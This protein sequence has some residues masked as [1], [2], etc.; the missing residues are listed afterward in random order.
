MNKKPVSYL[1]TDPRWKNK[2]YRVPGETATI[3][4]SGCGPTA[5][6]MLIETLTGKKYTPED[7][8][9]WSVAHG[10]KALKAGTY[11]A[12]FAPQFA[13]FGIK[14]WQLSWTNGYHNPKAKVHDQ[15]LEYL[16]Q[17]YY[18][19]ALMKKGT[20]TG[21]GHFVVVWWADNK[22][23]INDPASTKD[24]RLNGDSA[25]F[26]NEAA[27]YWVIDARAY[28]NGGA[29]T[30]PEYRTYTVMAGASLSTIGARTGVDWKTIAALNGINSPYTIHPGQVLKLAEETKK[31]DDDMDQDK[32]NK[33]FATAMQQYRQEL[34]DNDCGEWSRAARQFAV[35]NG[36]FAGSGTTASD[37][38]PNMMWEDLLTREQCAQVLYRFAQK[39]GLA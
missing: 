28:N 33:M 19:I 23:R 7:A 3:G 26:R 8:C 20:W 31:E 12:Y 17:G 13:E 22:I 1:Q 16:K 37:G 38:Q 35:D 24:K 18:L 10:Y 11:Y 9:A 15:A 14:C 6:A 5:A 39:F 2:P 32:F 34:R 27:Y 21:G 4:D 36:I 29:A 25:T 30:V